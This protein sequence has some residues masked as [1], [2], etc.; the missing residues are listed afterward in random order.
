MVELLSQAQ[1]R[2]ILEYNPETGVF[3][4][5]KA[6]AQRVKIGDVAGT[7]IRGYTII[8]INNKQHCAHRLVWLHVYGVWPEDQIDHINHDRSDNRMANLREVTRKEN[9]KNRVLNIN[10]K[11]GICGVNWVNRENKWRARIKSD[12]KDVYLGYFTDKFEAI[13]ARKSAEIKYGF[14]PNHG[15][16]GE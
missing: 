5:L 3:R 12:K 9:S 7:P 15:M 14:H 6:T 1:L 8:K 16:K 11:S 4:W 2:D 10:S 13:C